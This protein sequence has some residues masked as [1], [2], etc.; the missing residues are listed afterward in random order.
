MTPEIVS[1]ALGAV[2]FVIAI[3][4]LGWTALDG[5]R[6]WRDWEAWAALQRQMIEKQAGELWENQVKDVLN[7][8]DRRLD[9]A[10]DKVR[11]GEATLG[12]LK[13]NMKKLN[14]A[15]EAA[16]PPD[17]PAPRFPLPQDLGASPQE[18]AEGVRRAARN[19]GN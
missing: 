3:A 9:E 2:S 10:D 11:R 14:S 13:T 5:R 15:G 8:L 4:A 12:A 1:V 6:A 17:S 18:A 7:R 16:M 19:G